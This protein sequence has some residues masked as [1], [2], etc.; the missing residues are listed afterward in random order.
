MRIPKSICEDVERHNGLW[1]RFDLLALD[2]REVRADLAPGEVICEDTNVS[3]DVRGKDAF[4]FRPPEALA[5]SAMVSKRTS[6]QRSF[7]FR[8]RI[9]ISPFV[10]LLQYGALKL[11]MSFF[12]KKSGLCSHRSSGRNW[13]DA[14]RARGYPR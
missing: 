11:R 4:H 6:T 9:V 3:I 1:P 2:V 5:S 10:D 8:L 14:L 13:F 12:L 7:N